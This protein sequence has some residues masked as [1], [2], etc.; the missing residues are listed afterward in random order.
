MRFS[1]YSLG[2]VLGLH[3]TYSGVY[4]DRKCRRVW[5]TFYSPLH[6]RV[7]VFNAVFHSFLANWSTIGA[8]L[9]NWGPSIITLVLHYNATIPDSLVLDLI[10][11][12][13][14]STKKLD[15]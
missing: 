6:D 4:A 5:F 8:I 10:A 11:Q 13:I 1:K 9:L 7:D 14:R 3:S 15:D 2:S 12:D